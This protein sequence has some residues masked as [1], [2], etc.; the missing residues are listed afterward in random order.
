M[1]LEPKWISIDLWGINLV[2]DVLSYIKCV[3]IY[4]HFVHKRILWWGG[5]WY[6][7]WSCY[8]RWI[9]YART[10]TNMFFSSFF[11]FFLKYDQNLIFYLEWFSFRSSTWSYVEANLKLYFICIL[12]MHHKCVILI[13]IFPSPK[14]I[15]F[16]P[17][18]LL[19]FMWM[20]FKTNS[21]S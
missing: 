10:I 9:I 16:L 12:T 21:E 3:F 4:L 7:L 19:C 1:T 6:S 2:I 14:R 15:D 18:W 17:L 13:S 5:C 20:W 8:L 11:S